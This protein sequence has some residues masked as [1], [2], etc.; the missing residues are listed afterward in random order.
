MVANGSRQNRNLISG[1]PPPIIEATVNVRFSQTKLTLAPGASA[2]VLATIDA[3][4]DVDQK[5]LPLVYRQ[6]IRVNLDTA[7]F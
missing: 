2:T 5:T 7:M 3:P 1:Y 4:K 6:N